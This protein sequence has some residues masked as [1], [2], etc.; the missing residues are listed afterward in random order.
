MPMRY[1]FLL[2]LPAVLLGCSDETTGPVD[3]Q[4]LPGTVTQTIGPEGGVIEL[5]GATVTFPE[6]ALDA[7]AEVTITATDDAAPEGFVA[8]SRIY[9]CEPSGLDFDP[10]V[11]MAM[12]FEADGTTPTMFWS[13]GADPTFQDVGGTPEGKV[14]SATVAHFSQGFVGYLHE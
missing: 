11:T 13:T 4:E 6:G 8:L 14:M 2:A 9:R 7:A 3:D 12:E 5:S 10:K 1:V